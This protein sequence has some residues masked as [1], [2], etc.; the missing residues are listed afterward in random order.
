MY[1]N[2][3]QE[4]L[5]RNWSQEYVAKRTNVTPE[6]IHYIETGQRKPSY[7]V[8]VNLEDLFNLNHRQLFAVVDD[9]PNSRENNTTNWVKKQPL[10]IVEKDGN[11]KGGG[12]Y[13]RCRWI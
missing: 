13:V 8:L 5:K 10:Y 2:I 11:K 4:R 6:T 9:T 3:R 1:L 12:I 7:E